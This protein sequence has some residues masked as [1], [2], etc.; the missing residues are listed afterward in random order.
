MQ[1]LGSSDQKASGAVDT[2]DD[3]HVQPV[4][5]FSLPPINVDGD[6]KKQPRKIRLSRKRKRLKLRVKWAPNAGTQ[7]L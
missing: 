6:A 2:F 1:A 4:H 5:G 3:F 7:Q